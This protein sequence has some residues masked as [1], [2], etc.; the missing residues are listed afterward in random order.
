[1]HFCYSG[2][3]ES[4]K[5]NLFFEGSELWLLIA[6]IPSVAT[7]TSRP[8]A[9]PFVHTV[10]HDYFATHKPDILA[11]DIIFFIMQFSKELKISYI[12]MVNQ[13][14]LLDQYLSPH[15]QAPRPGPV[16]GGYREGLCHAIL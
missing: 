9:D 1:M 8:D 15:S 5:V 12:F 13:T 11:E 4:Y 10:T 6:T 7:K 3:S 16:V 2:F 14:Y